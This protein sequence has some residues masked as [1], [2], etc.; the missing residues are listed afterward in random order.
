M[1][2]ENVRKIKEICKSAGIETRDYSDVL[3]F[4]PY[5]LA[6]GKVMKHIAGPVKVRNGNE[7][8]DFLSGEEAARSY[9][10]S[11]RIEAISAADGV[12]VVD[13]SSKKIEKND[14]NEEWV[15]KTESET[16]ENVSFF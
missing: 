4:D 1:S 16:G 13:I 3:E 9:S 10:G 2:V 11:G 8:K 6:F 7:V 12:I 14:I 15:K 5:S